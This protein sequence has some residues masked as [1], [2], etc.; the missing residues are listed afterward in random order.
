M[1]HNAFPDMQ[2]TVEEAIA[3]ND[4]V[5][6]RW[7]AHGTHLGEIMGIAPTR[8]QATTT[9]TVTCHIAN[10]KLQEASINWDALVS[11]N[12]SACPSALV[13]RGFP[14]IKPTPTNLEAT[15]TFV[16][17]A[18]STTCSWTGCS[19]SAGILGDR[20]QLYFIPPEKVRPHAE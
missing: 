5:V 15:P 14:L 20:P 17:R 4:I 18:T 11:C 12:N 1:D 2:Y 10:G 19:Q 8:K 3:E 13:T 7:T 6:W 16:K 9:G